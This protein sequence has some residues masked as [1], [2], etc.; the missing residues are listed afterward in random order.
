MIVG[1]IVGLYVG[2][3]W[4]FIGGIMQVVNAFNINPVDGKEI[5]I[6]ICRIVFATSIGEGIAAVFF[7]VGAGLIGWNFLGPKRLRR[8]L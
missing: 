2:L 4:A 1:I 5:A 6:G 8:K 7:L 3:W